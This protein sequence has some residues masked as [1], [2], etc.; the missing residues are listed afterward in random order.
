MTPEDINICYRGKQRLDNEVLFLMDA[1]ITRANVPQD[2]LRTECLVMW[3]IVQVE[4]A[5]ML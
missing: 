2:G 1:D 4:F 3:D 5:T